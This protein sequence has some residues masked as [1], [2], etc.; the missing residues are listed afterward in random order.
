VDAKKEHGLVG[1][2]PERRVAKD[3]S[4]RVYWRVW[5]SFGGR[6]HRRFRTSEA[7][8]RALVAQANQRL[9]P[10]R[11]GFINVPPRVPVD[12]FVF[13][14][15][16]GSVEK[17]LAASPVSMN[18]E[19][20]RSGSR[21]SKPID[22]FITEHIEQFSPSKLAEDTIKMRKI[23]LG[24]FRAFLAEQRLL[25]LPVRMITKRQLDDYCTWRET[26]GAVMAVTINKEMM[27]IQTMFRDAIEARLRRRNPAKG[28]RRNED[29]DP[30]EFRTLDEIARVLAEGVHTPEQEHRIRHAC[31]LTESE[32]YSLVEL[33]REHRTFEA[34]A[35]AAFTGARRGEIM[36]LTWADVDFTRNT[37]TFR[38]RKQS[39]KVRWVK[40]HVS[41]GPTLVEILK[42]LR[43][44]NGGQGY[45]FPGD[46]PGTHRTRN[47]M[48][49]GLKSLLKGTK[50]DGIGWHCFRHT[51][52]SILA[53]RGVPTHVLC[54]VLGHTSEQM[55]QR[56]RHFYPDQLRAA[57]EMLD[58]ALNGSRAFAQAATTPPLTA[59]PSA[60]TLIDPAVQRCP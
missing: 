16:T 2:S 55:L 45:L 3:G 19:R 32:L 20:G 6:L 48:T 34:V 9:E 49:T 5:F 36:R 60:S 47:Q 46:E 26:A 12:D 30:E 7:Q 39:R 43:D 10:L 51:A 56:Y 18:A 15:V 42:R 11:R 57:A 58:P 21:R 41:V 1:M 27:T 31:I 52:A 29:E 14:G 23:H 17:P 22:V 40:R 53:A 50:F 38:S 54:K 13:E 8:A 4:E 24:H 33:A 25:H 28:V 35:V 59:E 37:I 44:R